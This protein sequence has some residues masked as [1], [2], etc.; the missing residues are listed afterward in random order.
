MQLR[1]SLSVFTL[2][3]EPLGAANTRAVSASANRGD[4]VTGR[5]GIAAR[6]RV[7][8]PSS[9]STPRA[10][11]G[12]GT[13]KQGL[14]WVRGEHRGLGGQTPACSLQCQRPAQPLCSSFAWAGVVLTQGD[15]HNP[16]QRWS[17]M[18]PPGRK[19]FLTSPHQTHISQATCVRPAACHRQHSI[20]TLPW[21]SC[22]LWRLP[23]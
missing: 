3:L 14:V 8:W 19:C 21:E 5:A 18:G 23:G 13:G 11:S 4:A 10:S 22:D 7:T 15:V 6:S 16:P 2:W 12:G 17:Q 1:S 9:L 20:L